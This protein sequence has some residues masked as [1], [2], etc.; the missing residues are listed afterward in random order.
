[1]PVPVRTSENFHI[2]LWLFKDLCWVMEYKIAGLVMILP[3]VVMAVYIAWGYRHDLGE[4]LHAVAVVFWILANST[5]M[6]GEFFLDDGTRGTATVFFVLGILCVGWFYLVLL[7][8]RRR[9]RS[10]EVT[11][12]QHRLHTEADRHA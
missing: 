5:W 3:T 7:P 4:A 8:R 6:I 9:A 11:S 2:V 1:M 10:M 12:V